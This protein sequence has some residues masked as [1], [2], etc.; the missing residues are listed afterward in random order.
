MEFLLDRLKWFV[1]KKNGIFSTST[2]NSRISLC[3]RAHY[4]KYVKGTHPGHQIAFLDFQ[5]FLFVRKNN[6]F[7]EI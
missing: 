6:D 3:V 4:L 1:V 5:I 7:A 2:Q